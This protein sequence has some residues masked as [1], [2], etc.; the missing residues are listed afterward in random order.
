MNRA[1]RKRKSLLPNLSQEATRD[2]SGLAL[3]VA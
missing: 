2:M 3:D 1:V